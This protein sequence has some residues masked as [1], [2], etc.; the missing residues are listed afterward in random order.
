MAW[1]SET[2]VV[3]SASYIMLLTILSCLF[4]GQ[5]PA[6]R[7]LVMRSMADW[8]LRDQHEQQRLSR[9]LDVAQDLKVSLAVLFIGFV[10]KS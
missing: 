4:Q 7:Q 10:I 1:P 2:V 3:L 8:Y 9:I 6:I 5:C